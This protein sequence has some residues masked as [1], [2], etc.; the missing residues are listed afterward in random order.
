MLRRLAR[1]DQVKIGF[2]FLILGSPQ[3][4][5]RERMKARERKKRRINSENRIEVQFR[6]S[7]ETYSFFFLR[8]SEDVEGGAMF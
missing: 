8:Q 3:E 7:L 6:G 2:N 5:Q 4:L 1:D